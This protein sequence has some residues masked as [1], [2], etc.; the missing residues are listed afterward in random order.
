MNQ[1]S[2]FIGDALQ[3]FF[4]ECKII[5]QILSFKWCLDYVHYIIHFVYIMNIILF[6]PV[7]SYCL[8]SYI[9]F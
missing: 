4:S 9:I 2:S 8:Y 3:S 7:Y 6:I 5:F 1:L